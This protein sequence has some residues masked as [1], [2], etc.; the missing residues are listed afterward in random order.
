LKT[1]AVLFAAALVA[2][3]ASAQGFPQTPLIPPDALNVNVVLFGHSWITLMEGFQPWAFPN[4]PSRHIAVRGYSGY[5]CAKL[6]PITLLNVPLST[7][8]VFIMAATNDV[9][10]RVPVARHI[11]CMK[12]MIGELIGENPHMLILLS[13]VPPLCMSVVGIFG[14]ERSTIATYNQAYAGL[15][16]LYP[17]NVQLVDM[18][19]P[20][21][22][23]NGWGLANM[24]VD[25]VHFGKNGQDL[26]MGTIRDALY[27]GLASGLGR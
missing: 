21:V 20:M 3:S 23:V 13:N 27:S 2:V 7:N 25:G 6:L 26:V 12:S 19:T 18:W 9:A 14:D 1:I 16:K 8:A 4:I 5:T 24:F 22:D 15:P 11:A 10:E 17:N